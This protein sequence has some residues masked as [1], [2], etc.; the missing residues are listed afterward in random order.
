[1]L[2]L[3][4]KPYDVY[5]DIIHMRLGDSCVGSLALIGPCCFFS[6][7]FGKLAMMHD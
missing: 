5:M 2:T 4:E 7:R 3:I 1:V 6:V